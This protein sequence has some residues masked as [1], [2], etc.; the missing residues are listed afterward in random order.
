MILLVWMWYKNKMNKR[1]RKIAKTNGI[2]SSFF[3]VIKM[4][5]YTKIIKKYKKILCKK[6]ICDIMKINISEN[7]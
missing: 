1:G 4:F 3:I 7:K 2:F 5:K 6:A